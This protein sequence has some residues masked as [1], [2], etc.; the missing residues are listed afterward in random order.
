MDSE[1]TEKLERAKAKAHAEGKEPFDFVKFVQHYVHD[2]GSC[3]RLRPD[4]HPSVQQQYEELYYEF[5]PK[6]MTV[7][8]Y[9]DYLNWIDESY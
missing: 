7:V 8:E 3:E 4:E 2:T 5:Y 9:A 1:R 6:I